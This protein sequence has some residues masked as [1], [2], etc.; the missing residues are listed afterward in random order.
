MC[1][2]DLDPEPYLTL[3]AFYQAKRDRFVAGLAGTPLRVLP[4]EGAYFQCVSYAD[5]VELRDLPERACSEWLTREIGVTPIPLSAFCS[6]PTEQQTIRFCFAKR[7][8]TLDAALQR[9]AKL[10]VSTH[11]A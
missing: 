3:P 8:D 5:V 10:G 2:S 7:D 9:L 4:C 11:R 6:A 1:S